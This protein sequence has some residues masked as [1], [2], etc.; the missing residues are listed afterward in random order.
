[1]TESALLV[2][3]LFFTLPYVPSHP[4]ET[5]PLWSGAAYAVLLFAVSRALRWRPLY[6]IAAGEAALFFV[7]VHLSNEVATLLYTGG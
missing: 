5:L 7:F 3:A 6:L 2:G 1:M 4:I